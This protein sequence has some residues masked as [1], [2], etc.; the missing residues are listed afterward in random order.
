M[1]QIFECWFPQSGEEMR[2]SAAYLADDAK[3]AAEK[4]AHERCRR[5]T[6]WHDRMVAVSEKI[7][8]EPKLFNVEVR[9]EPIFEA[10]L[11]AN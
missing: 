2:D 6:D 8:D 4:A 7:G 9:S 10:H 3:E 1:A 11:L 5:T